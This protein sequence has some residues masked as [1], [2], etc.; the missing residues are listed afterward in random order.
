M[1]EVEPLGLLMNPS[2]LEEEKN[3]LS[4][5]RVKLEKK[6]KAMENLNEQQQ[7]EESSQEEEG[8]KITF[9]FV[10][11]ILILYSL[12]DLEIKHKIM[13]LVEEVTK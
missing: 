5:L 3:L 10:S 13:M 2:Y 6:V 1:A 11:T 4:D 8:I 9:V 7:Q 12:C